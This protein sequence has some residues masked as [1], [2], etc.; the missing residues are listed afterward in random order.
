MS[1]T[2]RKRDKTHTQT[3]ELLE[4]H[5][6]FFVDSTPVFGEGCWGGGGPRGALEAGGSRKKQNKMMYARTFFESVF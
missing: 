3:E 1:R 6:V 4:L 2:P 5:L